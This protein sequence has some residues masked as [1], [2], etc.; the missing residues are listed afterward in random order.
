MLNDS[1]VGRETTITIFKN[2]IY[3]YQD[4][5]KDMLFHVNGLF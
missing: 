5:K 3:E 4:K 2:K 1:G